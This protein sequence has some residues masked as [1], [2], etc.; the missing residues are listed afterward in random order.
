LQELNISALFFQLL[1]AGLK[2]VL[3]KISLSD[4]HVDLSGN[5]VVWIHECQPTAVL[6]N[7]ALTEGQVQ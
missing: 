2:F 4:E 7:M 3:M 6:P 5:G 1:T